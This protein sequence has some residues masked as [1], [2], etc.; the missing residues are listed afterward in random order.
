[1]GLLSRCR[2]P[3]LEETCIV[4]VA[5]D[6]TSGLWQTCPNSTLGLHGY[7]FS[8]SSSSSEKKV[9]LS[10]NLRVQQHREHKLTLS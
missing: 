7:P 8:S 4:E 9:Q 5:V 2:L 3:F 1:M 10:V 6:S